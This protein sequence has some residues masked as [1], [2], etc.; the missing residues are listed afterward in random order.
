MNSV[1]AALITTR[2]SVLVVSTLPLFRLVTMSFAMSGENAMRTKLINSFDHASESESGSAVSN[3][4]D[5][6]APECSQ[7]M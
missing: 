4:R 7:P 5:A 2:D 1:G 6:E 3:Q